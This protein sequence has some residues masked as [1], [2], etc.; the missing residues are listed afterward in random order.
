MPANVGFWLYLNL[1][2]PGGRKEKEKQFFGGFIEKYRVRHKSEP[3]ALFN[4]IPCL[5]SS[6][7]CRSMACQ[8]HE[9]ASRKRSSRQF[10]LAINSKKTHRLFLSRSFYV[11]HFL[12]F[13]RATKRIGYLARRKGQFVHTHFICCSCWVWLFEISRSKQWWI[14][15]W[16]YTVLPDRH[17]LRCYFSSTDFFD[18][19]T[20]VISLEK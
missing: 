11:N 16:F 7:P 19:A 4:W 17:R 13:G 20:F 1:A 12:W 3:V 6:C 15:N 2:I 8:R 18:I 5:L 14:I 9:L 10:F